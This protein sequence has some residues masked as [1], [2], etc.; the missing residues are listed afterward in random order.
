[1]ISGTVTLSTDRSS[2]SKK[3]LK[4]L[5][6][7]LLKTGIDAW[8]E[9]T[10]RLILDTEKTGK[11]YPSRTG[12]G[13]HQASAPG[14]PWAEDTGDL[15]RAKFIDKSEVRSSSDPHARGGWKGESAPIAAALEFGRRDGTIAP[16]PTA[17]PAFEQAK[18]AVL[19]EAANPVNLLSYVSAK[20]EV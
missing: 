10:D 17:I 8:D 7:T 2:E 12:S 9:E 15:R 1:M 19:K 14:E 5:M 18:E 16:R 4:E 11:I 3:A 6:A 20:G 13:E